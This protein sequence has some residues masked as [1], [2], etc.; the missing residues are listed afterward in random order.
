MAFAECLAGMAHASR[1]HRHA[2]VTYV[3]RSAV[4]YFALDVVFRAGLNQANML[5][6]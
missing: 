3:T 2:I 6:G 4:L 5:G 1:D